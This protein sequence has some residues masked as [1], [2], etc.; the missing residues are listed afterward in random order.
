METWEGAGVRCDL[1][2]TMIQQNTN[3]KQAFVTSIGFPACFWSHT[4]GHLY[5]ML[6]SNDTKNIQQ[7]QSQT[8]F[9]ITQACYL[10]AV[11]LDYTVVHNCTLYSSVVRMVK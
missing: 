3:K 5:F 6:I 1:R 9:G 2:Y 4:M 7:N 11:L 8:P 10:I